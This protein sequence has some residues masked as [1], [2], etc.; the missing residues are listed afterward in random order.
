MTAARVSTIRVKLTS[1]VHWTTLPRRP[2]LP[3]LAAETALR[4]EK[5]STLPAQ[6]S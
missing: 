4:V 5:K 6:P 1:K 3:L 2:D